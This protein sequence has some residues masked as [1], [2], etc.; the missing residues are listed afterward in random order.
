MLYKSLFTVHTLR[1]VTM[2]LLFTI[3]TLWFLIFPTSFWWRHG[4]KEQFVGQEKMEL[5]TILSFAVN[6]P[7]LYYFVL[8]SARLLSRILLRCTLRGERAHAV[9]SFKS[10]SSSVLS[11]FPINI[12]FCLR[13]GQQLR[14]KLR[15]FFFSRCVVIVR[16]VS[17]HNQKWCEMAN[18]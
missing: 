7:P 9:S 1:Y 2:V 6:G 13:N 12:F 18:R 14:S 17:L 15:C 5:L 10:S 16:L 4:A 8:W 3:F 11:F